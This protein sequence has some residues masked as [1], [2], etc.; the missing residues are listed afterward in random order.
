MR[1]PFKIIGILL[2]PPSLVRR[3]WEKKKQREAEGK[4]PFGVLLKLCGVLSAVLSLLSFITSPLVMKFLLK[5]PADP[6]P[7]REKRY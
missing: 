7:Y 4:K 1:I 2:L 6:P 3:R 5:E